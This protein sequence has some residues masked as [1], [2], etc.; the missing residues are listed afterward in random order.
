M[1]SAPS[2]GM[3]FSMFYSTMPLCLFAGVLL[4]LFPKAGVLVTAGWIA[5]VIIRPH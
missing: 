5:L 4:Y 1:T 2:C 3:T